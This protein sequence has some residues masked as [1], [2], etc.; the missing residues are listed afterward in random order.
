VTVEWQTPPS[1]DTLSSCWR[2]A[3]KVPSPY[4]LAFHLRS[5]PLSPESLSP[6]RSLVQSLEGLPPPF[7]PGYLFQ[8]F[9]LAL[10][11]SVLFPN[12]HPNTWPCSPLPLPVTF[13]THMPPS[14]LVKCFLLP[15]KWDWGILTWDLWLVSL[16]ESRALYP[17]NSVLFWLISTY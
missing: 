4:C 1:F 2:W 15:P 5:L 17:G 12:P 16:L 9:L 8:F 11:A 13:L 7:F 10:R 6:P 14:S 3:L